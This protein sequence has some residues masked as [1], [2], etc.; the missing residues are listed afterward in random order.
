MYLLIIIRP[1]HI[2]R[3]H[4]DPLRESHVDPLTMKRQNSLCDHLQKYYFDPCSELNSIKILK[5][6]QTDILK[7]DQNKILHVIILSTQKSENIDL[8]IHNKWIKVFF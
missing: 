6:D 1:G 8:A 7:V 4:F 3:H 2:D 5:L